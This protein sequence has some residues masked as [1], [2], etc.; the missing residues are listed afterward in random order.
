MEKE[1]LSQLTIDYS[2]YLGELRKRLVSILAIFFIAFLAGFVF[3]RQII[4]GFFRLF[5]LGEAQ[6]IVTSPFQVF[7][8]A[9]NTGLFLA[10]LTSSPLLLFHLINFIKPALRI[11]ERKLILPLILSSLTLF[12]FGFVFGFVMMRWVVWQFSQVFMTDKIANFW[13]IELFLSQ[14]LLTSAFLGLIFQFPLVLFFLVKLGIIDIN[15]LREKR[16]MIIAGAF[17]IIALLPPAD[18]FSLVL[19]VLPVLILFEIT[20]FALRK[21]KREGVKLYAR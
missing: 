1:I 6:I 5:S 21:Q 20:L 11:K 14:I 10:L 4:E 2:P 18:G 19:M 3:F 13:D 12:I 7:S 8:L 9:V 15:S 16:P 17:I